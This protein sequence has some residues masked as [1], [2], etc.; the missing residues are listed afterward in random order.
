[1]NAFRTPL[2]RTAFRLPLWLLAGPLLAGPAM[3]DDPG[4]SRIEHLEQRVQQLEAEREQTEAADEWKRSTSVAHLSGYGA[5]G[6]ADEETGDGAFDQV[7]FNPIFHYLYDDLLLFEAELEIAVEED[8]ETE[9]A[10]EYAALNLF[11]NDYVVV[12]AGKFQSPLGQFRQNLHPAWINKLPA[13]PVGFGH[14]GAAPTAEVGAY[15]RGGVPV[16]DLA[17]NYAVYVGNGPEVLVEAGEIHG[18]E[19]EGFT[20]DVDGDKVWGAR[21]G[22][23]PIPQLEFGV[24]GALGQVALLDDTG[25]LLEQ[26]RDYQVLGADFAWQRGLAEL[27][28]EYIIQSLD[29]DPASSYPEDVEWEAWYVQGAMRIPD[30]QVEVVA[31]YGE[32]DSPHADD[33]QDQVAAGINYLFA[34]NVIAKLAYEWN[35]GDPASPADHDRVLIQLAYGF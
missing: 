32:F 9:T 31:R 10:L 22:L 18:I 20:R 17:A 12:G 1:M 24:S 35:D 7:S 6:Y 34:S 29:D 13:A 25:A 14:D 21:L 11:A 23:L 5:V 3:A 16:G 30:T 28:G 19:S 8:G 26:D 15:L 2:D 4:P 27:R 33:D